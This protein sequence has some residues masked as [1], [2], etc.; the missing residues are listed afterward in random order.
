MDPLIAR[1]AGLTE[2]QTEFMQ[3]VDQ[4]EPAQRDQPG[5]C[6]DWSAQQVVAH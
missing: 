4:L 3:V 5:V 1:L 2:A 6:G